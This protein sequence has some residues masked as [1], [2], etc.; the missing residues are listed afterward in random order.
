MPAKVVRPRDLSLPGRGSNSLRQ[1]VRESEPA[2][3]EGEWAPVPRV[4]PSM[5]F[6]SRCADSGG[7]TVEWPPRF[8]SVPE[9]L[10]NSGVQMN[11]IDIQ[12]NQTTVYPSIFKMRNQAPI[13]QTPTTVYA[14]QPVFNVNRPMRMR[15]DAKWPPRGAE[16][17]DQPQV[18]QVVVVPKKQC[19]DYSKFFTKNALPDSY[20]GYRAPPGTQ[21]VGAEGEEEGT[22][23]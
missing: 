22:D 8:G 2:H 13:Q 15:G 1:L 14:C 21:H 6:L 20:T 7:R 16:E 11:G 5:K 9:G 19:K 3:R 17:N 12:A 18:K 4:P 10:N 23:M